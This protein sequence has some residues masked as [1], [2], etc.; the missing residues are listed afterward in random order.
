MCLQCKLSYIVKMIKGISTR[1]LL[2][3]F[4][5]LTECLWKG[6]LWNPSYYVETIGSI[7]DES[8]KKNKDKINS[9]IY[10]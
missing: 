4:P 7:S 10:L 1:K 2:L 5:V 8:I 3:F 9:A 6:H